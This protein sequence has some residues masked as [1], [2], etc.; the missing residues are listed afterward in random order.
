M[1]R[2]NLSIYAALASNILIAAAKFTAG[3]VSRSAAMT[4][5]GIHSAAD[6]FNELFLLVGIHKSNRKRQTTSFRIWQGALFMVISGGD[7][8]IWIWRD[9]LFCTG[10][11]PF[12]KTCFSRKSLLE[13]PG[14]GILLSL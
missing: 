1:A 13:L 7:H 4:S 11:S 2:S 3:F 10:L 6:C 14:A 8:D 12:D 5:E 9:R